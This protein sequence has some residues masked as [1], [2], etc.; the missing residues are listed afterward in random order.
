APLD[1]LRPGR[2][3]VGLPVVPSLDRRIRGERAGGRGEPPRDGM[4]GFGH[5]AHGHLMT[6]APLAVSGEERGRLRLG[7]GLQY[8][9]YPCWGNR[10]RRRH[11]KRHARSLRLLS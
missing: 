8:V 9:T 4:K 6:G 11:R 5:R 10:W 7:I 1:L 3:V 2:R